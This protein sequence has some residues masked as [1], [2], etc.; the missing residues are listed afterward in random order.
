MDTL[1]ASIDERAED[2]SDLTLAQ[3]RALR[4][5][6][7]TQEWVDSLDDLESEQLI[8]VAKHQF[9]VQAAIRKLENK[10]LAEL[11]DQLLDNEND[12][13]AAMKKIKLTIRE[14][15][16]TEDSIAVVGEF[17]RVVGNLVPLIL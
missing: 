8:E 1:P 4:D 10:A 16:A 9:N 11:R 2:L 5:R 13:R 3:L 17:L 14:L 6:F 7:Q 12:I 15:K